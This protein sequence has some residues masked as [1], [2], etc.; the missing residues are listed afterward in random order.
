[1][2]PFDIEHTACRLRAAPNRREAPGL[3]SLAAMSW[4]RIKGSVRERWR[5]LTVKDLE[6]SG[7]RAREKQLA[8][9][10]V[11]RHKADPI[12]K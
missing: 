5:R 4:E 8:D 1:M 12:H 7:R 6:A 3:R 10:L 11:R 9:W 2:L